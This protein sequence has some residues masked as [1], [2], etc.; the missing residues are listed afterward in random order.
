MKLVTAVAF[1]F[2]S[3]LFETVS[4]DGHLPFKTYKATIEPIP[5]VETEVSGTVVVFDAGDGSMVGYG[6]FL[7]GLESNLMAEACTATNGCGTVA[8]Q[9]SIVSSAAG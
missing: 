2:A 3:S 8:G 9:D 4:A 1:A 7:Y 6:G 5:G